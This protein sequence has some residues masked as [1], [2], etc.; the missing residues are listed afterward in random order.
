MVASLLR[1]RG[2]SS[3][4]RR[5]ILIEIEQPEEQLHSLYVYNTE[6]HTMVACKFQRAVWS[7]SGAEKTPLNAHHSVEIGELEKCARLN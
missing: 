3:W 5:W 4:K 7:A 2:Q 6:S 1:L